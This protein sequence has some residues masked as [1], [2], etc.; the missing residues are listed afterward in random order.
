MAKWLL[1]L[2]VFLAFCGLIFG[3]LTWA[4]GRTD[5]IARERQETLINLVVSDMRGAIAHDQ[6]SATVWDDAVRH[7]QSR[8]LDWI[9]SNLG[10]WMHTYFGHDAVLV[11]SADASPVY[12]F[13]APSSSPV[14]RADLDA[15]IRPL[16]S[17]LT[18]RLAAEDSTGIT[19][20]VLSIGESDLAIVG[21]RP[22][23]VS[24]KPIVSDTGN[25][26]QTP[27]QQ[28]LHA[29][30]RFLD[31]SFPVQLTRDYLFSDLKFTAFRPDDATRASVALTARSGKPIGYFTWRPFR[32]GKSVL[33]ATLPMVL[34]IG[35]FLFVAVHFVG[36]NILRRAERLAA[37]RSELQFLALHDPLTGLANRAHFSESLAASLAGAGEEEAHTVFFVDLDRFKSVNDTYGHP[38][39]DRLIVDV[40]HRL[41]TALPDTLIARIGGDEF[42]LFTRSAD[43]SAVTGIADGIVRCL[44]EPYV[45]DGIQIA[46]GA[47]VGA[48][49][50]LGPIDALEI[51][52]QADIALYHAKAAGRNRFAIF[53]NH[54]DEVLRNRREL[55]QDLRA[56]VSTRQI[57]THFQ[58]V[59][60]AGKETLTSLEALARW[61]HPVRGFVAP[62]IFIPVAE[63]IGLIREIGRIVLDD[64]CSVMQEQPDM[65]VAINASP[66]E[67]NSPGYAV[68]VLSTLAR[69]AIEPGR[70][71]IEITE[72]LALGKDG[73]AENNIRDL[74]AAGVRF[75][76]DDF[77]TGYSSF[78]RVQNVQVDR[79][80]IDRSFIAEMQ[81]EDEKGLVTAMIGMARANGLKIT[82]EGVETKGQSDILTALGCDHL[83]GF[84]L[85]RP[86]SRA[87]LLKLLNR[88]GKAAGIA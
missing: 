34:A 73:L 53:G 86:L 62:D 2:A 50:C 67:L 5:V 45:I 14:S 47:S 35:I 10:E 8:D 36:R 22:A 84:F 80:K 60:A 83:Q 43:A 33:D 64:A 7:T 51:T 74:R 54:M 26:A 19:E 27:G 6:E 39:G 65:R 11:L 49:T 40:A 63:E 30:I 46:I 38:V 85:S 12:D 70:L 17:A 59:Y 3:T 81:P 28:Y 13:V 71:E 42:T 1:P 58:P 29:S 41:R 23:I 37:S 66:L 31:D 25:I 20:R 55:E 87:A 21:H 18:A 88:D 79:I 44:H 52:R 61:Q 76:I 75:A 69:W 78:S 9:R 15:A 48:A 68:G 77:G 57:E 24:V 56:A 82:A 4:A 72:N 16:A 32:P